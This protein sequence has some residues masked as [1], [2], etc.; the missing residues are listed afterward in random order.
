MLPHL[1]PDPEIFGDHSVAVFW[2]LAGSSYRELTR[3]NAEVQRL[4]H[5]PKNDRDL[6]D[7]YC[8]AAGADYL[9]LE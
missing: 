4:N 5:A 6:Y 7:T 2:F 8:Q 3:K 1:S 9:P